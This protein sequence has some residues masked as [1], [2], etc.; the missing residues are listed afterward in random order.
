M[1]AL[2]RVI[3]NWQARSID[4]KDALVH[5]DHILENI[6]AIGSLDGDIARTF[7]NERGIS[8]SRRQELQTIGLHHESNQEGCRERRKTPTTERG[9]DAVLRPVPVRDGLSRAEADLWTQGAALG[10][11]S[12][13]KAAA[14]R[15]LLIS[16]TPMTFDV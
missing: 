7:L 9:N 4:K 16:P 14:L 5:C 3:S 11:R 2:D 13:P 8:D 1:L 12:L 15:L 10:R 6:K